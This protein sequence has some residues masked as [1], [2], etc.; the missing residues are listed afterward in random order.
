[1]SCQGVV[2]CLVALHCLRCAD[3]LVYPPIAPIDAVPR[4]SLLASSMPIC[5]A[6]AREFV[7][8]FVSSAAAALDI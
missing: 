5:P 1:M 7:T 2:P 3:R 6:P 8:A 4:S